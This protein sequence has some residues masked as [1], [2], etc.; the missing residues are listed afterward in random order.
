MVASITY[1]AMAGTLANRRVGVGVDEVEQALQPVVERGEV[2][3]QGGQS[4][5]GRVIALASSTVE[6][7]PLEPIENWPI[8]W[9]SPAA[10]L[11]WLVNGI[12][13]LALAS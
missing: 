9:Q 1:R 12:D 6:R 2:G 8:S 3:D 7:V 11:G 10:R 13:G 4:T 5:P